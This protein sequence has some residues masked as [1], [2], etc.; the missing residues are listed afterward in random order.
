MM[1][2]QPRYMMKESRK[3]KEGKERFGKCVRRKRKTVGAISWNQTTAEPFLLSSSTNLNSL[4]S[5]ARK[6]LIGI[7]PGNR[8]N[9]FTKPGVPLIL[10]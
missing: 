7:R 5:H 8:N 1:F 4:Q 10:L 3:G 2:M 9:S 6:K